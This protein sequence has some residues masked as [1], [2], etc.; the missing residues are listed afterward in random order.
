MIRLTSSMPR[1]FIASRKTGDRLTASSHSTNSSSMIGG[2]TP[3]GKRLVPSH[4]ARA[5]VDHRLVPSAGRVVE[6]DQERLARRG[7]RRVALTDDAP[8]MARS[9]LTVT[10]RTLSLSWRSLRTAATAQL[11]L[12][13]LAAGRAGVA[14]R[15]F[16]R[17][18]VLRLR[19]V[20]V[21]RL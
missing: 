20:S 21:G 3:S 8:W 12:V 15:R 19:D 10:N 6:Q 13:G 14:R 2:W 17:D 4:R 5:E 18:S 1:F 11:D 7:D 9:E 16:G